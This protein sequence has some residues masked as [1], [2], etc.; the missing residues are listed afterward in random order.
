LTGIGRALVQEGRDVQ[1]AIAPLEHAL[2]IRDASKA[3]PELRAETMFALAQALWSTGR[4]RER[5]ASLGEAA[6]ALYDDAHS[7]ERA[8]VEQTLTTWRGATATGTRL[9]PRYRK[10]ASASTSPA[11]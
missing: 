8:R 5:A 10:S 7:E 3:V 9:R 2:A 6:R 11:P 1:A 4:E